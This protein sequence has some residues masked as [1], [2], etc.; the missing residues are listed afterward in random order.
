MCV[1]AYCISRRA[2]SFVRNLKL[3]FTFNADEL[4]VEAHLSRRFI[5]LAVF[6]SRAVSV[7]VISGIKELLHKQQK[8]LSVGELYQGDEK[9]SFSRVHTHCSQGGRGIS[10]HL[11]FHEF[12]MCS[13]PVG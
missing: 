13:P 11:P 10:T 5:C 1:W 9:G 6:A 8:N 12:F 7:A 2:L 4:K 3:T